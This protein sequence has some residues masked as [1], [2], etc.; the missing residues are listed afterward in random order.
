MLNR[1]RFLL[2]A[3]AVAAGG[4]AVGIGLDRALTSRGKPI[5][6]VPL[7]T[8]PPGLPDR[9]HAWTT[10]LARDPD[11]NPVPPR[12]DRL[13]FFNIEGSPGPAHARVLEAALRTLERTYH[14]GPSGLLFTAAWGP[15][16]FE[17]SL[18]VPTPIPRAT[19]LS[20]FESPAIDD[21]D[22]CIHLACDEERRLAAIEA[23]LLNTSPLPGADGPLDISSALRWQ[24]TRTGF[25]GAGLPAQRQNAGGIPPGNPVPKGAPLFMGFKSSLR[26]NQASEDDVTIQRGPFAGGMTM[27]V[28]YMRLSLETWYQNLTKRE[29]VA[30]MYAPQVTPEQVAHFTTDASS[31]PDLLNQ[32]INR[33]G[34][35]GHAQTSARARRNNKPLI[36]RRDFNT[37]DG[38]QAGLHFVSVQRTIED[39]ITTRNAMTLRRLSSRIRASRTPSTTGSTSSYSSQSVPIT[40][41]PLDSSG[42]SRCSPAASRRRLTDADNAYPGSGVLP[43]HPGLGVV[44][45]HVDRVGQAGVGDVGDGHVLDDVAEVLADRDPHASELTGDAGILGLF[46]LAAPNAGERPLDGTDDVGD[47]DLPGLLGQPVAAV[48]AALTADD[49]RDSELG[50]DVLEKVEWNPL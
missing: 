38:G 25:T 43:S 41:S 35:V 24:E 21:Y 5:P 30:R 7:G 42:R 44:G 10:T 34:V 33:Y 11:G 32:A 3:A 45:Q 13:V 9:Q 48:G 37:I 20:D 26:R 46:G 22:L 12:F 39:F 6:A 18:R 47:R 15:A 4:T 19:G 14:W 8:Q 36:L 16:Y 17:R 28:S 27:Q 23:A 50:E 31:D 29:R 49:S 2:G 1:R 40:S